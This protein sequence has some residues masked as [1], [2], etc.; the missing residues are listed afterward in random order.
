V[1]VIF[2]GGASEGQRVR[3][4]G[5]SEKKNGARP[6]MLLLER[7]AITQELESEKKEQ[8]ANKKITE[9]KKNKCSV[10]HWMKKRIGTTEIGKRGLQEGLI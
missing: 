10:V 7:T 2:E 1:S 4:P 8:K 5:G 6:K 3:K 9:K